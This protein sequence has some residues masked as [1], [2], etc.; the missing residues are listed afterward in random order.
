LKLALATL[1]AFFIC[2]GRAYALFDSANGGQ[3]G[4]YLSELSGGA[5]GL[6]L[7]LAQVSLD[8]QANLI[9]SNPAAIAGLYWKETSFNFLPLFEQSQFA[10]LSFACPVAP[11]SALGVS[12]VRLTSGDAEKTNALGEMTGSFSDQETAVIVGA[13]T[14][15]SKELSCG[16]NIKMLSQDIDTISEKGMGVDLGLIYHY[17]PGHTWGLSLLN[18]VQPVL[19]PDRFPLTARAGFSHVLFTNFTWHG[20]LEALNVFKSEYVSRW[21]T[22]FEF[23]KPDWFFWRLG[24]N[25]QQLS[26]GFGIVTRQI[27]IDYAFVYHPLAS[28]QSISLNLRYGYPATEAEIRAVEKIN[29]L[30]KAKADYAETIRKQDENI[31]FERERLKLDKILAVKF[32]EARRAFEEKKYELSLKKL[33]EILKIDPVYEEAKTLSE[34][35]RARLSSDNMSRRIE[36]ARQAYKN[37]SFG[38][39]KEHVNFILEQQPDN[40]EARVLGYLANAQIFLAGKSYKEAKGEL[41]EVMKIDPNNI[42]ASGLL[43]RVQNII[44]LY[45]G[46]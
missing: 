22:G 41:I 35:I 9:Y 32:I 26:A 4:E 44:D 42:E 13:G 1:I 20:D 12:L 2:I 34:E 27:D 21:Y 19:G 24:A 33:Q 36:Y 37:G 15:I 43:K 8:G 11:G 16:I 14:K 45:G 31:R 6:A 30:N 38:E 40:Q 7:G 23:N 10:S 5:R 18:A 29:E 17:A 25:E 3:P 28:L 46:Q 39:A